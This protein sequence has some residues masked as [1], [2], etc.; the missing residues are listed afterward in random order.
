MMPFL[1]AA[2]D[3]T[4]QQEPTQIVVMH[5]LHNYYDRNL[6]M[7]QSRAESIIEIEI[8]LFPHYFGQRLGRFN[9][10]VEYY[11]PCKSGF[12][13]VTGTESCYLPIGRYS[14]ELAPCRVSPPL[15]RPLVIPWGELWAQRL[16]HWIAGHFANG[17]TVA[18]R[19]GGG[20]G[21]VNESTAGILDV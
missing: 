1:A 11:R 5:P 7:R 3:T 18:C 6:V 14:K 8:D 20:I 13:H 17:C 10:I 4:S 19:Q 21:C 16:K 12:I 9:W 2:I 15:F